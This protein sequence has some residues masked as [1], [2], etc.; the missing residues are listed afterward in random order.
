MNDG[1]DWLTDS[2]QEIWRDWL[3]GTAKMSEFLDADLRPHG[4]RLGEYAILVNLSEA[5]DGEMRMAELAGAVHQS[6]SRLTH[7][8]TRMESDGLLERTT[9]STDRRGVIARITQH[10]L[11]VLAAAAPSHVAAVR[12]VF[13]DAVDPEDFQAVGRAMKVV[14]SVTD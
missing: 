9:A 1:A 13:V 7:A 10:G 12:K 5:P 14:L 6:R 4:L 3:V 2:Q 8:V 11:D